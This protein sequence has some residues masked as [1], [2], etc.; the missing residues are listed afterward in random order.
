MQQ[1]KIIL[2]LIILFIAGSAWLF[3]ASDKLTDPN[4]GKNW[5]AISFVDPTGKGL[6]FIIENHSDQNNFHWE[7][8]SNNKKVRAGD[9]TIGKGASQKV[10]LDGNSE[11]GKIIIDVTAGNE[12]KEIYK[13][14]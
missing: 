2:F 14:L 4:T 13:N 1:K 3:Y 6:S 10:T 11:P 7:V 5:W 9:E 8:L 12:K